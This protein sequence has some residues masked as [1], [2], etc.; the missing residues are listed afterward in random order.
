[1]DYERHYYDLPDGRLSAVHFNV[2]AGPPRLIMANANG[3]NGLSYRQLLEPLGVH[4]VSLDLRGHGFS[5]LPTPVG[6]MR[7]MHIF[8]DDILYFLTHY[9]KTPFVLSG[10]SL[11]ASSTI[12]AAACQPAH[13][14]GCV[15]FDPPL[16]S[17]FVRNISYVPGGLWVMQNM[18]P[19][20]KRAGQRRSIFDSQQAAFERYQSR[21]AF[22]HMPDGV[23]WDYLK[24]GLKPHPQGVQLCCDPGFEQRVYAAQGHNL[25]RAAS[26]IQ[27][28][29]RFISAGKGAVSN[30]ST[31]Q[32][33]AKRVGA[34]H[35]YF[36]PDFHHLFPFNK[37][38]ETRRFLQDMLKQTGLS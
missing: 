24:G 30:R 13:L 9:I 17:A 31:R 20:A 32:A 25:F 5:T 2:D 26:R 1:M 3:F 15:V 10:H 6:S 7:N 34:D 33:M 18:L 19:I 36:R 21:G 35:Y 11:G 16:L 38:D 22:H 8:R 28:P 37:P 23:L 14:K 29:K 27:V 12:L 4:S